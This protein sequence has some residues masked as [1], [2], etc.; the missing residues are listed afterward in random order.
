MSRDAGRFLGL[1]AQL[2][3]D[4]PLFLRE[5]SFGNPEYFTERP[6]KA[7]RRRITLAF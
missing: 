2:M 5:C 4:G 1:L 6:D 3:P 7:F